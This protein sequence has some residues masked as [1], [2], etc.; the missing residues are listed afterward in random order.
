[1]FGAIL[2]H[3]GIDLPLSSSALNYST[4]S[5]WQAFN[6]QINSN[7]GLEFDIQLLK[8]GKFA[9]SH[10]PSL[11]RILKST[12]NDLLINMTAG[13]LVEKIL[14]N[15]DRLCTLDEL[16]NLIAE[17]SNTISALHLKNTSQKI[18]T[19]NKLIE[20]LRPFVDRLKNNL[21]VFDAKPEI[22]KYLKEALPNLSLAASVSHVDDITRFAK[23]TGDTL[24]SFDEVV[25]YREYYNWV[26]LDEWDLNSLD[27]KPKSLVNSDTISQCKKHG[28][29]IA[30]VSPELHATSPALLGGEA[31]EKAKDLFTLQKC[32]RDWGTFGI[33]AICTDYGTWLSQ[34]IKDNR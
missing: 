3:R 32:W 5:S 6:N 24:L 22:A 14:P 27:G 34:Q 4:E 9:I 12:D 29:K 20:N 28:F 21:I 30:A 25:K 16:I 1:M 19:I 26:W 17:K 11:D 2:T 23:F 8:D 33:D 13:E 15:G 10:D 18:E 7:L 31:H